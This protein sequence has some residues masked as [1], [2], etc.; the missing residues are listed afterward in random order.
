[1]CSQFSE[2]YRVISKKNLTI[3]VILDNSYLPSQNFNFPHNL[4]DPEKPEEDKNQALEF[5]V[6]EDKRTNV[7]KD[8]SLSIKSFFMVLS[9]SS[10]PI[11]FLSVQFCLEIKSPF[12]G[13]GLCSVG[14]AQKGKCQ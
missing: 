1:M 6:V 4:I 2:L 10:N 11:P 8:I 12:K 7:S 9:K 3:S 14:G 5:A 13:Q